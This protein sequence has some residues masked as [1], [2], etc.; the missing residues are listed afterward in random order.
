MK[1][2]KNLLS[3]FFVITAILA[4][5]SVAESGSETQV[6]NRVKKKASIDS[7]SFI[8]IPS[9]VTNESSGFVTKKDKNR[10]TQKYSKEE[11]EKLLQ[12]LKAKADLQTLNKKERVMVVPPK[13]TAVLNQSVQNETLSLKV[14]N[15][16][17]SQLSNEEYEKRQEESLKNVI[18]KIKLK[19]VDERKKLLSAA[20]SKNVIKETEYDTMFYLRL[21]HILEKKGDFNQAVEV[22]KEIL[23]Q[24]P[25]SASADIAQK[26]IKEIIS[27]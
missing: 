26:R 21:G 27:K 15:I 12:E 3:I 24:S 7:Q 9:R 16:M 10:H 13:D 20:E 23:K 14:K 6:I 11:K 8:F 19:Q 18:E 2:K 17:N 5:I 4:F 22:Y 1:L 25:G